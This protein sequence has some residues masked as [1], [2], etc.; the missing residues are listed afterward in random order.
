M[1]DTIDALIGRVIEREGGYVDNPNDAGGPTKYGITL[2]TLHGWRKVPVGAADV[3]NLTASEAAQIYRQNYF[4]GPGLDAVKD[5]MIQE[6]L[7]DYAVNSGTGAAVRALQ[8]ALGVPADGS[9]GPQS[10]AALDRVNNQVALFYRLKCERYEL[11]LRF[12][13]S[14][15][16]N[17][18]FASGWANR[19]DQFEERIG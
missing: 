12:I 3:A 9:F 1:A 13:G 18:V 6:F 2:A 17:A 7:F 15:P 14:S 5:P 11:L 4:V 8:T 19:L 16:G 10:K